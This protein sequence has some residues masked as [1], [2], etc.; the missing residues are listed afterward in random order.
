MTQRCTNTLTQSLRVTLI[1]G[2][3]CSMLFLQGCGGESE[4]KAAVQ[5]AERSFTAVSLGDANA[6]PADS[7][8]IYR[9]AEQ[10]LAEHAGDSS[11]FAEAAAVGVAM[12][13]RGQ[14][15]L[16]SHEASNAENESLYQG[17]IIRGMINE[18][19]TMSAIAQAA[20][21][22]D[23]SED[24]A[25]VESI[26]ELRS[27]DIQYYQQQ[28]DEIENEI[29]THEA[30]ITDLRAKAADQ[31]QQAGALELQIPRVSAREGA[32][33]AEQVREFTLRADQ[34]DLEATRIEG[35]VEQL[36][37]S[38]REATLNVGKASSQIEL[39]EQAIT[40]LRERARNSQEDAAEA[41]S[42]ADQALQR[43][44]GAV[45][46]YQ[47]HR[48][49]AV[50]NAHEEAISLIRAA[51]NASRDARDAVKAVATINK[52][53][54]QQM[55]AEFQMRQATGE[56]EE[57]MLYQALDEAGV[58][59][60]WEAPMNEANTNADETLAEAKQGYLDAAN[61]LRSARARGEA[62][63]RLAAAA[64]RLDR[65]GGVEPEPEPE[66]SF[67]IEDE[68][69]EETTPSEPE[70]VETGQMSLDDIID[71]VPDEMREM[72]QAQ[73]QGMMDMLADTDDVDMLY[74]LIDQLDAQAADMPEEVVAGFDWVKQ[75]IYDR[76]DE[77]ES[78]G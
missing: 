31:R 17:R 24:I 30:K 44:Q 78:D 53:D 47:S 36:R 48:D 5:K 76:I 13:K 8:R 28:M 67:D 51:I 15:A 60:S 58:P 63:E 25:E 66:E 1:A 75:R 9:D 14:A 42:N 45:N 27:E 23:P 3:A 49:D 12:A 19:L 65:L 70:M 22:F 6:I 50:E 38:A 77:I 59:G 18:W 72:V 62:G 74:E 40:E 16:A 35:I 54:A 37:P 21:A 29:S 4:A 11:G 55:L 43:I 69:Q 20:G 10:S 64:E 7:A 52:A 41:R 39:L 71:S 2:C 61:T 68:A 26:I 46:E 73:L 56:R 57:A 32:K 34:F 33:L